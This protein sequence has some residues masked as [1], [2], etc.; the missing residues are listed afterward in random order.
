MP[1]TFVV[2][3]VRVYTNTNISN[4]KYTYVYTHTHIHIQVYKFKY[5]R[6]GP[7]LF[8]LVMHILETLS[9]ICG[10]LAASVYSLAKRQKARKNI[11]SN[12]T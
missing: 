4:N 12:T 3:T 2:Q 5:V 11:E 10:C 9:K 6:I 1:T 7:F 8:G